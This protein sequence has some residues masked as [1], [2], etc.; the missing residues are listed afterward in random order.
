MVY[1]AENPALAALEIR[2][3]LDIPPELQPDNYV[4]IAIETGNAAINEM[5]SDI[6]DPR[7]AGDNWL[8]Q[9]S[10]PIVRVPSIIVPESYNFLINPRHPASPQISVEFTKPISFDPRLWALESGPPLI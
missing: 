3:H 10:S 7:A 6:Q 1:T 8:S 2:V 4:L 9:L 5:P